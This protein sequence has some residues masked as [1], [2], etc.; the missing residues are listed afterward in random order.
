[1]SG[2]ELTAALRRSRRRQGFFDKQVSCESQEL[3]DVGGQEPGVRFD[4]NVSFI[5][6]TSP[7]SDT[8][9]RLRTELT[10]FK[11]DTGCLK[12]NKDKSNVLFL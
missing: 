12:I 4:D 3:G 10:T 2:E 11:V 5:E 7:D 6:A 1:M 9:A 8:D